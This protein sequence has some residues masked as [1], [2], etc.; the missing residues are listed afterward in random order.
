[1][2]NSSIKYLLGYALLITTAM[3]RAELPDLTILN[4]GSKTSSYFKQTNNYT[5]DLATQFK[6]ELVNPGNNCL[7]VNILN[8]IDK[9]QPVLVIW[10][11]DFEAA[12]RENNVC[13]IPFTER[14]LV[15]AHFDALYV[16]S[17]KPEMTAA[18]FI[19][20]GASYRVG[21]GL[22]INMLTTTVKAVN[23]SFATAH[24]PVPYTAGT[25]GV[26]TALANGEVDYGIVESSAARRI[27][28][29][30]GMHCQY[31]L[32]ATVSP[33]DPLKVESLPA[34][35][36]SN[37][38]LTVGYYNVFIVK[39]AD[40]AML[41]KIKSAMKSVHAD[42]NSNTFKFWEGSGLQP[43]FDVKL[44][45]GSTAWENAVNLYVNK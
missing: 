37:P 10:G 30:Q 44:S 4:T 6:T 11:S 38:L 9:K 3:A 27:V 28:K 25:A 35:D 18:K 29:E 19:E 45:T 34:K 41:A 36:L 17:I 8:K 16:C 24:K 39:N 22:P 23:Q 26:V 2:K 20:R 43:S 33:T 31:K 12:G 13:P 14:E 42:P 21:L 7:A 32:A 40:D 1:M 5:Q 15:R